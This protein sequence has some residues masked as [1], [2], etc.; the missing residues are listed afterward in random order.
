MVGMGGSGGA[1]LD[2]HG[3]DGGDWEP[4]AP[5]GLLWIRRVLEYTAAGGWSR[6]GRS[7]GGMGLGGQ[8]FLYPPKIL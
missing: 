6:A 7:G 3:V 1:G 5:E 4:M 8:T 2:W